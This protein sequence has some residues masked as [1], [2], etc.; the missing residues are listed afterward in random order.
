L[1]KI[2]D[3]RKFYREGSFD[4]EDL[5]A[6]PLELFI[7]WWNEA[8]QNEIEEPNAMTL[9]TV[10]E[11]GQPSARIILLKGVTSEGFEFFTNYQSKKAQEIQSNPNV[12]LV[13]FWKILERQVRI[14]GVAEKL[15]FERSRAYFQTRPVGS[16][17]GAWASPQSQVIPD[18]KIL[19]ENLRQLKEKFQHE[20][21]LPC[22]DFW[23]GYI[24]K[25]SLIEFWH[26]RPD[27]MHDRFRYKKEQGVNW[28][29]DRLAP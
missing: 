25:P 9:A 7:L 14:E 23:G 27:R 4:M 10:N 1:K 2:E 28:S 13:F 18:R 8:I 19:E 6:D 17:L 24:V 3:F 15:A 5:K 22:P 21:P 26:G 29:I 11:D 12:A 16:Q 20:S